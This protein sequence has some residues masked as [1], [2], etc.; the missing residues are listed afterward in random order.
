MPPQPCR[1]LREDNRFFRQPSAEGIQ[2]WF[3]KI[4]ADNP[5]T[6]VPLGVAGSTFEYGKRVYRKGG[7]GSDRGKANRRMAQSRPQS[8]IEDAIEAEP[9]AMGRRKS[10]TTNCM[11]VAIALPSVIGARVVVWRCRQ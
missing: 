1:K 11:E 5:I 4:I 6:K 3:N 8:R 7:A 10:L 9:R 2:P